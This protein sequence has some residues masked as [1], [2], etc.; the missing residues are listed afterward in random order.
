MNM[1][2]AVLQARAE[3]RAV[4][5]QAGTLEQPSNPLLL[6]G[7]LAASTSGQVVTERTAEGIPTVF[8]CDRVIKQDVAKSPLNIKKTNDDKS[9]AVDTEHPVHI[10]LH[11]S[12]NPFM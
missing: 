11:E 5:V 1:M 10:A 3:R 2:G 9:R 8:A 12:P 7:P 6:S 4:V